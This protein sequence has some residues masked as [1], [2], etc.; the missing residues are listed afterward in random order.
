MDIHIRFTLDAPRG[1]KRRVLLH[2]VTPLGLV[3]AVSTLAVAY[4]TSWIASGQPVSA[5]A[6]KE[7]LDEIQTRLEDLEGRE[8]VYRA[9]IGPAGAVDE[10]TGSWITLVNHPD[11]GS[12]EI[13]FADDVFTSTPTCVATAYAGN[14]LP[15]A[16]ECYQIFPTGIVCA[17]EAGGSAVDTGL[18]LVC[19]GP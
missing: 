5:N 1:W 19:V 10:Q 8:R 15:P 17:A 12:Y 11:V 6:L 7:N 18:F 16:V 2:I 13:T 4:D 3:A 14:L 9:N